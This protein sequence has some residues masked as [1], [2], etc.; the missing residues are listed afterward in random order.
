[1]QQG[2]NSLKFLI[3]IPAYNEEQ[4]IKD[5]LL[6]L[7]HQTK[8]P[9]KIIVVDDSSTDKTAE[10]VKSLAQQHHLVHYKKH[11]SVSEHVPGSKIINAFNFGLEDENLEDYDIVCKYDADL[12]FPVEYLERIEN[13]FN[14][15]TEL[16]LCGGICSV[17]KTG[18]GLR[19]T[20]QIQ[21]TYA[22]R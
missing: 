17:K 11:K 6:S 20:L 19:R 22:A 13:A 12:M 7:L 18:S 14:T 10:V 4:S 16:G 8:A 15:N 3:I 2:N 21:T 5:C 9:E 1:M